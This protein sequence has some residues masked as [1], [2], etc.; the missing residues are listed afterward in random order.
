[1]LAAAR[2][3]GCE[4]L[5][6]VVGHGAEEVR[7]AFPEAGIDWI[8]QAEQRGTG[9][10]LAQARAAIAAPAALLVLS[11]DVPLLSAATLS[12]LAAAAEAGW[13]A[14]AVATLDEPGALGRVVAAPDGA[15]ARI[16]EAADAA[17]EELAIRRINAGIYALPAPEIFSFLDR[18]TPENAKGELYLTDA[19]GLAAAAGRRIELVELAEPAEA[20]GSTTARTSRAPTPGSRPPRRAPWRRRA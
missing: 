3:A 12:R 18:L 16:V 15:L 14:M 19:L 13:G 2:A 11:G 17:P 7:A 5:S 8:V 20:W 4:R 9:H 10:A 6:V 1:M